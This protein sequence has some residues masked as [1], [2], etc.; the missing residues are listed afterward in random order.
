MYAIIF[1]LLLNFSLARST[2][3]MSCFTHEQR[4]FEL[5]YLGSNKVALQLR[6]NNFYAG[7]FFCGEYR[8]RK[9][10][11]GDDDSGSFV[12]HNDHIQ[13]SSLISL[14]TPDS[15]LHL[16]L[17]NGRTQLKLEPCLKE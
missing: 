6:D 13:Q 10:C 11:S 14:G 7:T 15:P 17:Q 4:T 5:L 2:H 3:K 8:G 1:S 12:L 9:T 16:S